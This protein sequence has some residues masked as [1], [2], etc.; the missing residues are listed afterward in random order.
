MSGMSTGIVTASP[1]YMS[2][3][4]PLRLL[5]RRFF[6]DVESALGHLHHVE[7]ATVADASDVH[8]AFIFPSTLKLEARVHLKRQH[9]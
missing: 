1:D 2:G 3:A 9:D 7:I 4:F 6:D 5:L 8:Y